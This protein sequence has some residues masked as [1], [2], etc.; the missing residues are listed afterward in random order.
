MLGT[1]QARHGDETVS[2]LKE[3]MW[4]EPSDEVTKSVGNRRSQCNARCTG[5]E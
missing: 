1:V 3:V 4:Q 5:E 2:A